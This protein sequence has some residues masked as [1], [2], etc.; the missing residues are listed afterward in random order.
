MFVVLFFANSFYVY[1][2][3]VVITK[4]LFFVE[5]KKV[6]ICTVVHLRG[7]FNFHL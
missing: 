4:R 6:L 3:V 7:G 2:S 1:I 5:K